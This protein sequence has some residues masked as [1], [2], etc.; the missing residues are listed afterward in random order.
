MA[1]QRR[2]AAS[3]GRNPLGQSVVGVAFLAVAALAAWAAS[4]RH[5]PHAVIAYLMPGLLICLGLLGV[6]L[7]RRR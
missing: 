5:I 2:T 1:E 4:G 7:G 6:V 3:E